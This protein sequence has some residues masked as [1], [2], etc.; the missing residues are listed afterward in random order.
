M[1]GISELKSTDVVL[2]S[3]TGNEFASTA[4]LSW[5]VL[6]NFK[7]FLSILSYITF[8]KVTQDLVA[9]V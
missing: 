4:I 9:W 5:G 8:L 7:T 3:R 2:T 6:G 1:L